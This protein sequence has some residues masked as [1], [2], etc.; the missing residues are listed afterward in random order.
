MTE[1]DESVPE[2]HGLVDE[3]AELVAVMQDDR[4]DPGVDAPGPVAPRPSARSQQ[5][6]LAPSARLPGP[7]RP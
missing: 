5:R 6:H 4:L 2:R 1:S 7:V 3:D